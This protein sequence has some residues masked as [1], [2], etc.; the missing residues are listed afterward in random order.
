MN[1]HSNQLHKEVVSETE[2]LGMSID[3][4]SVTINDIRRYEK[5]MNGKSIKALSNA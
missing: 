2:V 5:L 1:H 4:D 3:Q